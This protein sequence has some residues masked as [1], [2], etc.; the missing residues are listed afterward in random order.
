MRKRI[1]EQ[2]LFPNFNLRQEYIK[3]EELLSEKLVICKQLIEGIVG[4]D[5][6]SLT[7]EDFIEATFLDW[8]LRGTFTSVRE[9]RMSLGIEKNLM[10]SKNLTEETVLD[11][12][13]YAANCINRVLIS[14]RKYRFY[15]I[16]KNYPETVFENIEALIAK[17][18][19]DLNFDE[20]TE[21]YFVVYANEVSDIVSSQQPDIEFSL[22]E[23]LRIDNRHDLKR[24]AE[25]LCTLY[26]KLES[27]DN[28][29][30]GSEFNGL[31]DDVDF[32]FNNT[33]IRHW[34]EDNKLAS[35]TFNRMADDELEGWY[36]NTF[37]LFLAC[38]VASSYLDVKPEIK[39]IKH[40]LRHN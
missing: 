24:K 36:D 29:F 12:L 1:S 21:E 40:T 15:L 11:F 18:G 17:L 4:F 30:K 32:L 27:I 16:N 14:D 10:N 33:G 22:S 19:A 28:K 2:N 20:A 23:Y 31:K 25:I 3:I 13:Q 5:D 9:M 8:N 26:K 34:V 39:A 6:V 37:K 7:I 38:M 35:A